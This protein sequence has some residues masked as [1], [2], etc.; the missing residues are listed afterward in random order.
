MA[1]M[2]IWRAGMGKRH[3]ANRGTLGTGGRYGDRRN[4]IRVRSRKRRGEGDGEI[5][6]GK[7][8]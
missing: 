8:G 2:D 5:G 4:R 6:G 7:Q 3:A 1:F